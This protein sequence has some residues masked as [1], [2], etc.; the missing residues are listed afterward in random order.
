VAFADVNGQRLYYEVHGEGEPL[1]MHP[2]FGCT[3]EVYWANIPALAE[4]FRVVVFDPRGSARSTPGGGEGT[5]MRDYADDAAGLLDQLGIASAHVFGASFGGMVAQHIALEH[6]ER[7]RRLVLCCT[8][9]GGA[10]HVL[11]PAEN[12]AKFV[13]ASAITD[14]AAAV[15]STYFLNYSEAYA[16]AHDAEIV[17]R[18]EQNAEL[19]STPEGRASQMAAVQGHDTDALLK[20]IRQPTLVAHGTDDGTV[21]FETGRTLAAGIPDARLTPYAGARHLVFTERA[22]D[23]NAEIVAF[24]TSSP[25]PYGAK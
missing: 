3:V 9:P 4:R 8:T 19:R 25:G 11:P 2:G 1:L 12:I 15:R 13:A 21:P 17:A 20:D 14:P 23:L 10:A 16:A 6:P 24:L 5:T 18:A 22:A 7:V